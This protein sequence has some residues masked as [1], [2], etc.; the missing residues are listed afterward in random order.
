MGLPFTIVGYG[1]NVAFSEDIQQNA[2]SGVKRRGS[3]PFVGAPVINP[4]PPHP[5][6]GVTN[7]T[8]RAGL[9][10][11][12]GTAPNAN[13]CAGDSGGPSIRSF[14]GQERVWGISTWTGDWCES[15]QYH[16]RLDPFL[17][18]LDLAYQKGGQAAT[19]PR[20]ECVAT[21][22]DG[23]L[24]A[25]FGYTNANGVIV[26]VPYGA[27]NLFAADTGNT[28]PNS[29]RPGTHTY[30]FGVSFTAG[31]TL[32]WRLSAPNSPTTTLT[33]NA[34]SP[35]CSATALATTC[36][37]ACDAQLAACPGS[38]TFESCV[39]FCRSWETDVGICTA[40]FSAYQRC[41]GT[42]PPAGWLCEDFG[43]FPADGVCQTEADAINA[44]FGG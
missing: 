42:T 1:A 19:T 39:G 30:V 8:V 21:R 3:A 28:R 44:C 9:F 40:E 14:D 24:R 26:N 33:V 10:Q 27:N 34:N 23:G 31:Q 16:T 15:F 37:Q 17:P 11:L 4:L 29:F 38:D 13:G 25:Y 36:A 43:A 35:R 41:L 5:H 7:P 32:S 2:G 20:L 22:P 6:P 18:F 12:N